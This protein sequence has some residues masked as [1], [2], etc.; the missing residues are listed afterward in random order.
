MVNKTPAKTIRVLVV[1][2]DGT[3][4]QPSAF[5]PESAALVHVHSVSR[6]ADGVA[7]A[8][9]ASAAVGDIAVAFVAVRLAG[10]HLSGAPAAALLAA[11]PSIQVVLCAAMDDADAATVLA[12]L[13]RTLEP[14]ACDRLLLQRL[15]A[16]D[17][18]LGQLTRVLAAKHTLIREQQ[19][20]R[21]AAALAPPPSRGENSDQLHQVQKMEAIGRLAG[22]VAHDFNN[23]LTAILGYA[24]LL[25]M[26]LP[27]DDRLTT[28]AQ[29]IYRSGQR[30]AGVTRQLLAFS[31]RQILAPQVLDL[32]HMIRDMERLLSRLIGEDIALEIRLDQ[33]LGAVRFDPSQLEQVVMNLVINARDSL[34]A[35]R[36]GPSS[37]AVI[38]TAA[39]KVDARMLAAHQHV[40]QIGN[41]TL[42]PGLYACLSVAD[43]GQGMDATT[44][45]HIFEP[46][47]TTK[48]SLSE[49]KGTGL[50][51][52][53]VYGIIHQSGGFIE[54]DSS[55]G[56]GAIFRVYL[57][58]AGE[59]PMAKTPTGPTQ[60]QLTGSETVLLVEDQDEVR[61]LVEKVLCDAG[62]TVLA[63]E[64]P[65]VAIG[66]AKQ[67][68][69]RIHVMVTDMVMPRMDGNELR[70]AV[71]AINPGLRVIFMSGYPD[72][73]HALRATRQPF[74]QKPFKGD[75]LLRTV[76][77]VL[78]S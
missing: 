54:V 72:R 16:G 59:A 56:K 57:P 14:E 78:E 52:S 60:R 51:L 21:A 28:Y 77:L 45:H 15:P 36:A 42:V 70:N 37:R 38:A 9:L 67:F 55:L 34:I 63:A 24:E 6:A 47:F 25:R 12:D 31:R 76:R 69:G 74:L 43:N 10:G 22:G 27:A 23:L 20:Q 48:S 4:A 11:D 53:T 62:Y 50:G 39:V 75:D 65:D 33:D 3:S 49:R 40:A 30:A 58:L 26:H 61:T 8:A 1:H 5:E 46:F 32:N 35:G 71:L 41:L 13:Q 7:S 18:L 17:G 29:E 64:N 2:A 68:G 66:L 44:R 73:D 19:A